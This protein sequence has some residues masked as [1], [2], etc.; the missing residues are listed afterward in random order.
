M[1]RKLK[2]KYF[3]NF[4]LLTL[5]ASLTTTAQGQGSA[6]HSVC[7]VIPAI[8]IVDIEPS[9]API[10]LQLKAPTEAGTAVEADQTDGSKWLNY[11]SA[12]AAGGS[13]RSIAAQISSGNLPDGIVLSLQT[14]GSSGGGGATGSSTGKVNLSS[15]PQT[16]ITGIGRSYT[17]T[18]SGNGHQLTYGLTISDY[19]KLDADGGQNVQV[20][21]TI[22]E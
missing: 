5:L 6:R 13:S 10:T 21:F 11:T 16:I 3:L 12:I 18:G 17:G 2:N 8:A 14:S 20:I 1:I 7:L 4:W 15:T 19:R 22:T 9:N